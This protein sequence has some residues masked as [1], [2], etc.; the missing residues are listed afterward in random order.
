MVHDPGVRLLLYLESIAN[1]QMLAA[2]VAC[3][4]ERDLPIVAVK[5]G[6][7]AGGQKAASSHTGSLANEDRTVDAFFKHYGIWRVRDPHEQARA[8]Q[9][10]LKGWRPE[11]RRLVVISNPGASYAMGADATEDEG[12]PLAELARENQQAVAAQLPGFATAS[13]PIDITT[14]LLID[15]GLF[16]KV[17]PAVAQ[18]PAADLFFINIPVAGAG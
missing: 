14:A 12:R 6:R 15:S 17:L 8:A 3:A 5:A 18:A 2:T 11:G 4:R 10:Y 16:G 13:N 9:A 1:P 7:S